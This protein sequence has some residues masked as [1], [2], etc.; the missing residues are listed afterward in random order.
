MSI[1]GNLNATPAIVHSVTMY[2]MRL[3][4]EADLPLN[5]GLLEPIEIRIPPS[6]ILDPSYRRRSAEL[7]GGGRRQRRDQ[8]SAWWIR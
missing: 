3:L 2:V 7:S 6:S 5:E 1:A 8:S 4:V